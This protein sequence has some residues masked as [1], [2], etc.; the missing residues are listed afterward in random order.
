M[1]P[2]ELVV[3]WKKATD[4]RISAAQAEELIKQGAVN[5]TSTINKE[6]FVQL[7]RAHA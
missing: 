7:V 1:D 5:G 2:D 6:E 4:K 3:A